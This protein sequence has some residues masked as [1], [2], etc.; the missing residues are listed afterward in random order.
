MMKFQTYGISGKSIMT[1]EH[2]GEHYGLE[3]ESASSG[4]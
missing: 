3:I 2:F 1:E 4:F